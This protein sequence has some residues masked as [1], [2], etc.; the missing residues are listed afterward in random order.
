MSVTLET[1]PRQHEA[2]VAPAVPAPEPRAPWFFW[3]LAAVTIIRMWVMTAVPLTGDEAYYWQWSRHLAFGYYDH[4]PMVGWV[5]ALF[6]LVLGHSLFST[7]LGGVVCSAIT[8]LLLYHLV[9][10]LGGTRATASLAG[11]LFLVAPLPAVGAMAIVPDAPLIAF[12]A[13]CVTF[14]ARALF[15]DRDRLT[16]WILA[17]LCL[18]LAAMSKLMAFFLMPSLLMFLLLS[19]EHRPLLGRPGPWVFLGTS[20]VTMSPFLAWNATHHWTTFLYQATSRMQIQPSPHYFWDFMAYE[21]VAL[22]PILYLLGL[23]VLGWMLT[24]RNDARYLFLGSFCAGILGFFVLMSFRTRIGGHWPFPGYFTLLAGLAL[25]F[26]ETTSR[27]YRRTLQ[28]GLALAAALTML[29]FAIVIDPQIIFSAVNAFKIHADGINKGQAVQSNELAEIYGY[30]EAA[31]QV[32]RVQQEM[33][34]VHPTFVFTD[35]YTLSSALAFY[36]DVDTHVALGSVMGREYT[37]W[38]HFN[39]MLGEDGLFVDLSPYGSRADIVHMLSSAFDSVTPDPP[40]QVMKNGQ[41][42]RSFYLIR[43][44]HFKRNTFELPGF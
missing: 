8:A 37:R 4:P 28:A 40:L 18:G 30:Q 42:V 17:G 19:R 43:C 33:A 10:M 12:W 20:L 44:H 22:G 16:P 36:S 25:V 31:Q 6:N 26:Q 29:I 3:L 21:A 7:R 13:G 41:P 15:V 2:P 11:T 24:R 9:R 1:P 32:Q 35:S 39:L 5:I 27:T 38:D 34:A 23:G 14:L